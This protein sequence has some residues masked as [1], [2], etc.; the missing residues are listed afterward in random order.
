[1][2]I[3]K[4]LVVLVDGWFLG[5]EF[6]VFVLIWFWFFGCDLFS[7]WLL[8]L[9]WFLRWLKFLVVMER[10]FFFL[11]F[12]VFKFIVEFNVFIDL[13]VVVWDVFVFVIV[14]LVCVLD[15]FKIVVVIF[16]LIFLFFWIGWEE[17]NMLIDNILCGLRVFEI[18]FLDFW[19]FFG[20]VKERIFSFLFLGNEVYWVLFF[21][22]GW[23]YLEEL[24]LFLEY[25]M[26]FG[27]L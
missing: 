27:I 17:W 7:I 9:D 21:N 19:V 24:M 25:L 10:Y 16:L 20:G 23:R 2:F 5:L 26:F 1:M 12:N 14:N 11:F 13:V 6:V 4:I 22:F 18:F 8:F 15:F 3:E